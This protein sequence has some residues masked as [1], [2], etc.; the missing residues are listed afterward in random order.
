[1]YY[2][3]RYRLHKERREIEEK[4][5]VNVDIQEGQIRREKI[6]DGRM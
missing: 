2:W 1:L 4:I 5:E 6:K 3:I